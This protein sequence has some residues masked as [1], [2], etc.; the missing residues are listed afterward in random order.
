[1]IAENG[2]FASPGYPNSYPQNAE[3]IWRLGGRVGLRNE[4]QCGH[5]NWNDLILHA[6]TKDIKMISYL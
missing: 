6:A 3:C 1:M 5:L 2:Y 4:S